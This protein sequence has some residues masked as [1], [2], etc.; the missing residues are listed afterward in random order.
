[1]MILP[2]KT[3]RIEYSVIGIGAILLQY[4]SHT[5]SVSSLWEKVK[6]KNE[7]NTYEKFI[8]GLV[9][10]FAIGAIVYNNGVISKNKQ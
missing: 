6:L 9:I 2:D 7:I 5:E 3:I 1:M 10:L 4:I 8:S